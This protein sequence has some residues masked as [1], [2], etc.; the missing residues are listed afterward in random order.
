[1]AAAARIVE[2]VAYRGQS[3]EAATRATPD[4]DASAPRAVSLGTLRWYLRLRPAVRVLLR[5]PAAAVP[6]LEALLTVAAHQVEYA[7][8]PGEVSVN[9]AVDAVRLLGL[10]RAAGLVNAV[11]R[12]FVRERASIFA[13]LDGSLAVRTAHPEWLVERLQAAWPTQAS[14]ILEANN[15]HPPMVLRVDRGRLSADAAVQSLKDQGIDAHKI[16]WS[17]TA[18]ELGR[19]RP[20]SALPGFD[21][22]Q[23]SVQDAGAQIAATLLDPQ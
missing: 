23:L 1:M 11:L 14:A 16:Q 4:A 2:G 9:A 10:P 18:V 15:Q 6:R 17:E 3:V 19:P 22:G 8:T 20:V 13:G 7:R 21:E 5:D 12:R